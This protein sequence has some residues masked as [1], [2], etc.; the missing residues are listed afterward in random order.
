[1]NKID[2]EP[3]KGNLLVEVPEKATKSGD[4][5]LAG[6]QDNAAPVKGTVLR[7]PKDYPTNF[8]VGEEIFFRKY[9]I[10]ELKFKNEDLSEEV[11]FIIEESEVLGVIRPLPKVKKVVDKTSELRQETKVADKELHKMSQKK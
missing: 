6:N 11:V 9:A 2:I 7:V 4:I 10:D 1:M 8:V 5:I 3:T